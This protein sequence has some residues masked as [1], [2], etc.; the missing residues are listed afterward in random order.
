MNGL[1]SYLSLGQVRARVASTRF[2]A[3]GLL[4]CVSAR[5]LPSLFLGRILPCRHPP[6]AGDGTVEVRRVAKFFPRT[7]G[8]LGITAVPG[9]FMRSSVR[10]GPPD[11]REM[12]ESMARMVAVAG[13]TKYSEYPALSS[14]A[15]VPAAKKIFGGCGA[16]C[17]VMHCSLRGP[18]PLGRRRQ[19]ARQV[20]SGT[21]RRVPRHVPGET[22]P[23]RFPKAGP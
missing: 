4:G 13:G 17:V 10:G 21:A 9:G 19:A 5:V 11:K 16:T 14:V 22:A 7:R 23:A 1:D 15:D 3:R 12:D 2:L 18:S 6:A 20:A 8:Y